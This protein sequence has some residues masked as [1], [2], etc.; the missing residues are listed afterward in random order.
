[1]QEAL[2]NAA[3]HSGAENCDVRLWGTADEIHLT[4]TDPGKGFDLRAAM[5]GRGLGLESMRERVKLMNG[6]LVIESQPDRGTTIY[7]RMP[8]RNGTPPSQD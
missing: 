8:C 5:R 3:K 4:V 1:L 6:H 7:A 2:N